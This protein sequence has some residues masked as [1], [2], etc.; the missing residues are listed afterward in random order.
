MNVYETLS[1]KERI[2]GNPYVG[3]GIVIGKRDDG[4]K[5]VFAY[6]F[7]GRSENSRN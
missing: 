7:M 4:Q 1:M 5:A 6:F 3:R 2:A